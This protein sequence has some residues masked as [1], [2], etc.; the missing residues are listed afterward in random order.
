MS[1]SQPNTKKK[2]TGYPSFMFFFIT[3]LICSFIMLCTEI[4]SYKT[5]KSNQTAILENGSYLT[6]KETDETYLAKIDSLLATCT[7]EQQQLIRQTVATSIAK[8]TDLI[9]DKTQSRLAI[10]EQI[11]LLNKDTQNLLGLHSA[12]IQHEYQG[13]QV[14]CAVLTIIFLIFSFYSLFKTDDLLKQGKEGLAEL[15]RIKDKATAQLADV[16]AA[17]NKCDSAVSTIT[18]RANE[19]L[20]EIDQKTSTRIKQINTVINSTKSDLTKYCEQTKQDLQKTYDELQSKLSTYSAPTDTHLEQR[21]D[22]LNQQLNLLT[23]KLQT[24]EQTL[25]SLQTSSQQ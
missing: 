8:A 11:K 25:E 10:D 9:I 20:S 24:I 16:K 14:W 2:L 15:E 1:T 13:L 3:A 5:F 22:T 18:Q 19:Q 6:S 23:Q 12:K 21:I 17:T 7:L 4:Y